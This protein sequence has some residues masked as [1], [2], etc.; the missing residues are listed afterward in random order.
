M[1]HISNLAMIIVLVTGMSASFCHAQEA[2]NLR[3][4]KVIKKFIKSKPKGVQVVGLG[5]WIKGDFKDVL[6]D[7]TSDFDMRLF[8]PPGTPPYVAEKQWKRARRE[9]QTMITEEFGKDAKKVLSKTNLYAPSQLM[10]AVENSKDAALRFNKLQAVPN[11][12]HSGNTVTEAQAKL[13]SEG[14]YG[15]GSKVWTQ[16]YEAN[17]GRVFFSHK[18]K[19]YTGATD[20]VHTAEGHGKYTTGGMGNT[21]MGWIEHAGDELKNGDARAVAKHLERVDRDLHKG[22]DLARMKS[23]SS[24]RKKVQSLVDDLRKPG[25]N[26]KALTGR[27]DDVMRRGRF[28]AAILERIDD[29]SPA[30]REILQR[31]MKSAESNGKAWKAISKAAKKVPMGAIFDGLIISMMTYSAADTANKRN[32]ADA[33]AK[34][35]PDLAGLAPGLMVEITDA[36][37]E[38]AKL[39]GFVMAANNQKAMDLIAGIYT[40]SGR[41]QAFGRTGKKYDMGSIDQ[42]VRTY[43]TQRKLEAFVRIRAHQASSRDA[44][45][46]TGQADDK[47]AEQIYQ[48]AFPFLLQKWKAQRAKYRQEYVLLLNKLRTAPLVLVYSPNPAVMP[49][50]GKPLLVTLTAV[51]PGTD[52]PK[53]YKRMREILNIL[54]VK[55][56]YITTAVK[57][58]AK[59]KPGRTDMSILV[60]APKPGEYKTSVKIQMEVGATELGDAGIR[61]QQANRTAATEITVVPPKGGGYGSFTGKFAG[62]QNRGTINFVIKGSL[63]TGQVRAYDI[64]ATLRGTYDSK[65]RTVRGTARGTQRVEGLSKP[66]TMVAQIKATY[67]GGQFTGTYS[68]VSGG[69]KETGAWSARGKLS[70]TPPK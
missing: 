20:L 59:G 32:I 47:V 18:G 33:L 7:G 69:A 46:A 39:T 67:N 40:A 10:T 64:T 55:G 19:A 4:Q 52:M 68:G 2:S 16:S 45:S 56:S 21:T 26:T 42:L 9:L 1:R 58:S 11:L 35:I 63:V 66:V 48:K 44:G 14:L 3:M 36:C 29:A 51:F 17:K 8:T 5:S 37:L 38:E 49:A 41:E 15:E 53:I 27:I 65:T 22:R 24:F 28:E 6:T 60:A 12:S 30:Q 54:T 50:D 34:A 61:R 43:R 70:D 31:L 62:K 23:D 57:F 25:A 13:Y